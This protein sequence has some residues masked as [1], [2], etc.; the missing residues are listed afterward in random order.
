MSAE[1][2]KARRYWQRCKRKAEEAL[3]ELDQQENAEHS[4]S[5][6]GDSREESSE[7]SDNGEES[8]NSEKSDGP[9]NSEGEGSDSS[10]DKR[11][12]QGDSSSQENDSDDR[13]DGS[14]GEEE[15][16]EE[17]E[18]KAG[19]SDSDDDSRGSAESSSGD[20]HQ[21]QE[22]ETPEFNSA[23]LHEEG[24][25]YYNDGH[26]NGKFC[27]S[28]R[29]ACP[30]TIGPDGSCIGHKCERSRCKDPDCPFSRAFTSLGKKPRYIR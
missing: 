29:A 10:Q 23:E 8:D 27:V 3:Y 1:L 20:D 11:Q 24:Q 5:E 19:E 13:A 2:T 28:I 15:D 22:V 7:E 16:S 12:T 6:D 4:R 14:Q 30:Y 17:E 18:S 26:C 9:D 21:S 25:C